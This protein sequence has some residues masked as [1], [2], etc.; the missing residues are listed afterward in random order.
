MGLHTMLKERFSYYFHFFANLFE[1]C[2]DELRD[3]FVF[4]KAIS[5]S[6]RAVEN[7]PPRHDV[8][9]L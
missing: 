2:P 7:I 5:P 4:G 9:V 6:I 1:L 3:L 8:C